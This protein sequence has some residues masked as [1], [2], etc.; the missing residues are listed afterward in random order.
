MDLMLHM[1]GEK[2]ED[3]KKSAGKREAVLEASER[4]FAAL[5]FQ[6]ATT[7]EIAKSAGVVEAT[8]YEYFKGKEDILFTRLEHRLETQLLA[9]GERSERQSTTQ[10]FRTLISNFFLS[11][12]SKPAFAKVLIAD[13]IYNI[14]F[15]KTSAY[16]YLRRYLG[17]IDEILKTGESEGCFR[18]GIKPH[19]IKNLL[20]GVFCTYTLRTMY[21]QDCRPQN[22]LEEIDAAVSLL[23]RAIV[24]FEE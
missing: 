3:S 9:F 5:G 14:K 11:L 19:I 20:I 15:Y 13:G 6:N 12:L 21:L 7:L 16:E 24:R 4:L 22:L 1:L 2:S 23:V 10:R 18:S 17:D 8:L